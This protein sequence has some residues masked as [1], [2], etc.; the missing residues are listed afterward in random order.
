MNGR[1]L[2]VEDEPLIANAVSFALKREGFQTEI[3]GDGLSALDVWRARPAD[4]VILDLILPG[5]SGMDVAVRLRQETTAPIIMLTARDG[6]VDKALGFER[7]ADDYVV[8]PFS[9]VELIARVRAQLRRRELDR[10]GTSAAVRRVGGVEIDLARHTVTVDGRP[11]RLTPSEYDVL[12]LLTER[13]DEVFD[14]REIVSRLWSSDY[15]G[16]MRACDS[17]V[18]RL[19]RKIERDPDR[20]ERILSV[21]GVGYK[22][23][24]VG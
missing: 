17:H 14:R 2:I 15:V 8:K 6:D 21:R 7:G 22:I 19:R 10:A 23:S 12:A 16:D 5:L 3:A 20:P 4:L 9:M 1:I 11:V 18:A 24:P 13:P